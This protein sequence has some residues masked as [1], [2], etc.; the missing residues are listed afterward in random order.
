M[1]QFFA[2]NFWLVPCYPLIGMLLTLLWSPGMIRRTGPRPAGYVNLFTTF[3]ALLHGILAFPAAWGQPP[4]YLDIP[5]LQVAGLDLTIPLE[6]SALTIGATTLVTGM[7]FLAQIYAVGYLEM[8]WGWARFFAF[9]SLFEAGICS[10]ALCN[11]LF[12]SFMLLEML[13]LGT[14]LLVGFWLNQS[15]VVTGGARCISD[16]ASG[17]PV[18]A[19]GSPGALSPVR[20]LEF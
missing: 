14:Y 10:L 9:L 16:Q 19:D 11:S 2:E 18:S 3:L 13:T 17:R 15:M 8:D 12:F 5:W 20:H 4:L 6:I 7:N 1:T